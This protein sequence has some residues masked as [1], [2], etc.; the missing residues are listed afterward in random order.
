M[1]AI[2]A[3]SVRNPAYEKLFPKLGFSEYESMDVFMYSVL[4]VQ[5]FLNE[6]S[7]VFAAHLKHLKKWNGTVQIECEGHSIFLE[8]VYENVQR[9]VWTSRPADLKVMLTSDLLSKLIFGTVDANEAYLT[10]QLKIEALRKKEV[11]DQLLETLFP[12]KQFL[13][14]DFW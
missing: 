14:M 6:L 7:P 11:A 5:K 2:I 9:I 3:G 10:G 4:N 13:I 12:N 8:K 1:A